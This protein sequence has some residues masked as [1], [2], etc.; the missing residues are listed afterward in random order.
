MEVFYACYICHSLVEWLVYEVP[1]KQSQQI[2]TDRRQTSSD[3]DEQMERV[4]KMD[5]IGLNMDKNYR[6]D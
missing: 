2:D 5:I 4:D 6:N 3:T 1:W